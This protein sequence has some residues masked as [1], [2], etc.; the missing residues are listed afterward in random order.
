MCVSLFSYKNRFLNT[1]VDI[2][3][4]RTDG[5]GVAACEAP[6]QRPASGR[7]DSVRSVTVAAHS[8]RANL[9]C[10]AYDLA[11]SRAAELSRPI[12]RSNGFQTSSGYNITQD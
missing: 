11:S 9:G 4:V 2:N 3:L 8:L 6:S 7:H 10:P 1:E 5:D 12:N